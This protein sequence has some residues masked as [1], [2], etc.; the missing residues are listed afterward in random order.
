MRWRWIPVLLVAALIL[1]WAVSASSNQSA[2]EDAFR[3]RSSAAERSF[4]ELSVPLNRQLAALDRIMRTE[5][6]HRILRQHAD[7]QLT[8]LGAMN[9]RLLGFVDELDAQVAESRLPPPL[10]LKGDSGALGQ[11]TFETGFQPRL[12]VGGGAIDKRF[13]NREIEMDQG[14]VRIARVGYLEGQLP[15]LRAFAHRLIIERIAEI[16]RLNRWYR[17]WYGRRAPAGTVPAGQ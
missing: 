8:D 13:L 1:G 14:A 15:A 2:L 10:Q 7:N 5:A 6:M 17:A 12:P 9:H 16:Y 11:T 4:V 3:H